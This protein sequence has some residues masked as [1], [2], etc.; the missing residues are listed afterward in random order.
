MVD[1]EHE[2]RLILNSESAVLLLFPL[3]KSMHNTLTEL[4][5]ANALNLGYCIHTF[6]LQ[7]QLTYEADII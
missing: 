2:A 1:P 6:S 5:G 4:I 7:L 3:W